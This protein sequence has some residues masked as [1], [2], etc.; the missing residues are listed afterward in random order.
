LRQRVAWLDERN[1]IEEQVK[2]KKIFG[3]SAAKMTLGASCKRE[4]REET[5]ITG[6]TTHSLLLSIHVIRKFL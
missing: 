4:G 2:I 3:G 6:G 1:E 5:E